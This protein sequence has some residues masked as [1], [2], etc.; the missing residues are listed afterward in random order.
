MVGQHGLRAQ[1][2]DPLLSWTA[3]VFRIELKNCR[4]SELHGLDAGFDFVNLD[5]ETRIEFDASPGM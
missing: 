3:P 1:L 4:Y 2:N 5:A